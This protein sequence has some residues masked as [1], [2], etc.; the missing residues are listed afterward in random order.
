MSGRRETVSIDES[1]DNTT[2][3]AIL[4]YVVYALSKANIDNIIT[5]IIYTIGILIC[6]RMFMLL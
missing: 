3:N 6:K 2:A 1:D 4:S 5:N